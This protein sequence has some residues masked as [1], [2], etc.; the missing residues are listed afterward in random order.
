MN[1]IPISYVSL[2]RARKDLERAFEQEDW[3]RVA[4]CDE[5]LGAVLT[6]AFDDPAR[7][8]SLLTTELD[9]ILRLYGQMVCEIPPNTEICVG[10]PEQVL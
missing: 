6:Q 1:V 7:D 2:V 3:E 8:H 10:S 9:K 5:F 4:E